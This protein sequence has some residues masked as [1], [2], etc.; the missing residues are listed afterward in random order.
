MNGLKETLLSWKY[1][2]LDIKKVVNMFH[3]VQIKI[4][5]VLM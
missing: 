4:V 3:K 1:D 5:H 2:S